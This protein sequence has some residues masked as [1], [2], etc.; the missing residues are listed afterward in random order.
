M[1]AIIVSRAIF[2]ALFFFLFFLRETSL[3]REG[4][5]LETFFS[6]IIFDGLRYARV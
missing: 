1:F 3:R 5:A 6:W 2:L 4:S